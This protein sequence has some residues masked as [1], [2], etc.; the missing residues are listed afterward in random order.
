[1]PHRAPHDLAQ[2]VAAP[3]VRRHDAVGDEEAGRAQVIGD[4][5][6]RDVGGGVGAVAARRRGRRWPR[7]SAGTDRCRSS[8]TCPGCTAVMRSR[9]MPVSIERRRQRLEHAALLPVE[10]HEDVVPDLDQPIVRRARPD[11]SRRSKK[12][13][14]QRP[15]GPVSPICQKLSAAPNS[16]MRSLPP[17]MRFQIA[18]AS[19]SRGTLAS[20]AKIDDAQPVLRQLPHLGQHRPGEADGLF[21]EVVAE[22]EVAEH[23][24]ER[25]VPVR[26]PDVVEIVVLAADPHALLRR[27]RPRVV[28]PLA[29]EE[30]VL[31]L[32][33]PR[34][35][36]EQRRVVVRARATSWGR[37]GGPGWRRS[38]GTTGEFRER[39]SRIIISRVGLAGRASARRQGRRGAVRA[40][41][42]ARR[43]EPWR[44]LRAV[45]L[46]S[47]WT[48]TPWRCRGSRG[49][50]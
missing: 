8:R 41:R 50:S 36:E 44:E 29:A 22:R 3:L 23:L 27:R 49:A 21:L 28:A 16:S 18:N 10:L 48:P 6:H 33:H 35:G 46:R 7:G 47:R 11:S 5:A 42:A 4:D 45:E 13:S 40:A 38:R 19:S 34:V 14:E 2:H 25:V 31:E 26:R 1:M 39:S 9:P 15:H 17:R 24:E 43:A 37:C 30:H 12:I 32:V 20:P